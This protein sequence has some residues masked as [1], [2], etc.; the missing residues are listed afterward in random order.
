MLFRSE[1]WTSILIKPDGIQ[2]KVVLYGTNV[3]ALF[4]YEHAM[5]EKMKRALTLFSER[6]QEIALIWTLYE[7]EY[8]EADNKY[9]KLWKDFQEMILKYQKD[10]WGILDKS[11]VILRAV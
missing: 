6:S 7:Y 5:I 9:Q 11:V 2:K 4:H 10:G 1:E 3:S 8:H